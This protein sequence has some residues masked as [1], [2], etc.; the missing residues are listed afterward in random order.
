MAKQEKITEKIDKLQYEK[1]CLEKGYKYICGIDEVGRGPLAG[2]V[3]T[4]AVIMDL[5]KL[6]DGVDDSKKLSAKKREKF[7]DEIISC[8]VA[9]SITEISEKEIDEINILNATKK[10]MLQSVKSLEIKPDVLLID[11]V[12]LNTDIPQLSVIKGDALS[13]T[14]G[15]ASILAKVYRDRLM[16]E[17]D[18]IYPQYNFKKNAGYGTKEHITAI[19]EIGPCPI[20]RKTFIKNFWEQKENG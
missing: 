14:I 3:V 2:P 13:Y 15:C 17:Y 7:Y 1:Y 12:K 11:A 6:V 8:S 16:A 20:H 9:Y 5:T 4:C 19:K 10:C 18:K